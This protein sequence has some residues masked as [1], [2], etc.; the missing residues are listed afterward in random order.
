MNEVKVHP[1]KRTIIAR[2]EEINYLKDKMMRDYML[3]RINT[4]S[5]I[6]VFP[7]KTG[8]IEMLRLKIGREYKFIVEEGR[9]SNNLLLNFEEWGKV[10]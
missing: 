10:E 4:D 6:F 9:N 7:S 1:A 2:V 8:K 5:P 3:L